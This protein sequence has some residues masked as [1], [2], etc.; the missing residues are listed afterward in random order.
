MAAK[1]KVKEEVAVDSALETKFKETHKEIEALLKQAEDALDK[2]KEL[3]DN[4]GV[5]FTSNV[6]E[7]YDSYVPASYVPASF[8][9][10]KKK[11]SKEFIEDFC[12]DNSID[13]DSEYGESGNGWNKSYC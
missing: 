10:L 12:D 13:L 6:I 11:L 8:E 2:A 1:K 5:P 7:N 4:T 9:K 3:S